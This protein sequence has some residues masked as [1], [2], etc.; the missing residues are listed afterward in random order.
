MT[1][2]A[3]KVQVSAF[4]DAYAKWESTASAA[5]S[6]LWESA[7]PSRRQPSPVSEQEPARRT[8][9][10]RLLADGWGSTRT[11]RA[12]PLPVGLSGRSLR[13]QERGG[14]TPAGDRIRRADL[15][16]PRFRTARRANSRRRSRDVAGE[17]HGA[18]R[19]PADDAD[20]S[21]HVRLCPG[22]ESEPSVLRGHRQLQ[23]RHQP[24]LRHGGGRAVDYSGFGGVARRPVPTRTPSSTSTPSRRSLR[25][26]TCS[27][28]ARPTAGPAPARASVCLASAS[29]RTS[30]T[31]FTSTSATPETAS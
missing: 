4:P 5:V 13:R 7:R 8:E 26:A 27:A 15:P 31:T 21:Q 2:A 9:A 23:L 25:T 18:P 10:R 24:P 16:R 14:S 28:S 12:R 17:L 29:S 1:V 6:A 20:R 22:V 30:A 11:R 3:Q 19:R